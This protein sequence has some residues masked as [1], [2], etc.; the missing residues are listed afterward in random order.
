M[1]SEILYIIYLTASIFFI[2]SIRGLAFPKTAMIGNYFGMIGMGI[3]A[4]ATFFI[5]PFKNDVM[6]LMILFLSAVTGILWGLKVQMTKLPQMVALLNGV[7][8]LSSTFIG[9]AEMIEKKQYM[10]DMTFGMVIGII[11]FSG[12]MIAFLKLNGKLDLRGSNT[13]YVISFLLF[14]VM[15]GT[16]IEFY[17]T[18]QL[19][20]CFELLI[21]AFF[22]GVIQ[23]VFIGGA[24]MP[25]VISFLNALSGL[26]MSAIGFSTQNLLLLMTGAMVG[27]SG[28]IL[29]KIMAH[30]MN[31]SLFQIFFKNFDI[32]QKSKNA[33]SEV[34]LSSPQDAAFLMKN[35][36]KVIV[37][38][39][40]GMAASG[41]GYALKNLA[42]ILK[43]K[44]HV[45]VK[46]AIHPVA[47]RMP[48]HMNVLLAE[49][50]V[51]YDQ[52]FSLED[53]NPEFESADVAY[54][55]GANDITNPSAKTDRNSPL[56]GMPILDVSK[57]KTVLFVKR[58]LASGYA[59]T[60]N[61]LFYAFNTFMLFGDARKVTEEIIKEL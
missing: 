14:G 37:V 52:V 26:A 55:I 33:L 27:A 21:L 40:Y 46:F 15:I 28:I 8:G 38:P 7:G 54:V 22:L 44:Y 57:A 50:K 4:G 2:G 59:G 48:G 1:T 47:G 42:S 24:D 19:S 23:T 53:I 58:S 30:A 16:W 6:I 20:A 60:D 18:G 11:A 5:F 25:I 61:P 34:H 3:A 41:A 51:D 17:L 13:A 35:A 12:S 9:M 10:F 49:A 39:G 45:E 43:E 31:R 36:G 32:S 56:F 29:A